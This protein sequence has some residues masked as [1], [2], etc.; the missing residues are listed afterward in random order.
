MT[1]PKPTQVILFEDMTGLYHATEAQAMTANVR[2]KL[3]E[4]LAAV[5]KCH[6]DKELSAWSLSSSMLVAIDKITDPA[7]EVVDFV[8]FIQRSRVP[9]GAVGKGEPQ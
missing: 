6:R 1:I 5:V 3:D 2:H 4:F 9:S 7:P 8:D